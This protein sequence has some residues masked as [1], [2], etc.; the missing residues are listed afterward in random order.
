MVKNN[1]EIDL[2]SVED[3]KKMIDIEDEGIKTWQDLKEAILKNQKP[4]LT[5]LVDFYEFTMSQT[6]FDT[7]EYQRK[8]YF[9]VFFRNHEFGSG[10][11]IS[12]GLAEI[13][14]YVKNFHF[15]KGDIDYLRGTG[16]FTEDFLAYLKDL[17]F[18]GD[19]WAVPDGTPIFPNEPIITV[20]AN[21]IEAQLL[22]TLM[23]AYFNH[24]SLIAT[25]TKRLSSA[26]EPL[27]IADFGARRGH[28][29]SVTQGSRHAA[30][31]GFSSTSNVLAAQTYNL[32]PS[33]TM[34]HS[35][36][37]FYGNDYDAFMAYAKSNPYNFVALV[38]TFSTLYSGLPAAIKVADDFL[39]PN[40]YPFKGI[41]IDSG[42]L[43][44]LA[45]E[46]RKIL[47]AAGYTDTKIFVTNGLDEA[48]IRQLKQV[49]APIDNLGVGDNAIAPKARL[50]GV[51]KLVAVDEDGVA[52]PRIK[53]SDSEVKITNPGY[54]KVYRFYDQKTGYALGDVV[55]LATEKI[56]LDGYTLI[57]PVNEWR[58]KELSN[59]T[60][61]ELQVPIFLNGKLVYQ[62]PETLESANYC[63]DMF[64]TIYPE[65]KQSSSPYEYI[66]DLSEPLLHLKK[67]MIT[68][69][70]DAVEKQKRIGQ[71]HA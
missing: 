27:K 60:V 52:V 41:R 69:H 28:G 11:T 2:M 30:I 45:S 35:L 71:Y 53:L 15:T 55:A 23:L 16:Q 25:A 38:D 57:S 5:M 26:A 32:I 51:Y 70:K 4:N 33:G 49:N 48:H 47:D 68:E 63:A 34:A 50:G 67:Q 1:N 14:D 42:D 36:V 44:Y 7:G 9:D 65:I 18:T 19:I 54:K 10:Y 61:Q 40:G 58:R 64:A 59:Y 39:T 31:G 6:F 37:E 29:E 66:V 62:V 24:G 13:I 17:H 46:A 3:V 43:T 56:P 20:H 22:E 12:S 21:V 8:A